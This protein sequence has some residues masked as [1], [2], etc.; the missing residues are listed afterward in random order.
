MILIMSDVDR[1]NCQYENEYYDSKHYENERFDENTGYYEYDSQK[2]HINSD[3]DKI[4]PKDND[5][6]IN[7]IENTIKIPH[8]D[9]EKKT[10]PIVLV[11]KE[12][13]FCDEIANGTDMFCGE[14]DQF[15][16]PNSGRYVQ[17]CTDEICVDISP[18]LF[19]LKL[20][21]EVEFTG[22]DK[23]TN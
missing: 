23:G 19:N 21:I 5:R 3:H 4:H 11:N 10:S 2:Y 16:A 17:E 18:E 1:H 12:V 14:G 20:V 9:S 22:S 7:I 8:I 13:L 6:F 15:P